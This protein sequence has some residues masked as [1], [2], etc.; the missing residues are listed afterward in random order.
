MYPVM[1]QYHIPLHEARV[2][3][4]LL[5]ELYQLNKKYFNT[6]SMF[7]DLGDNKKSTFVLVPQSHGYHRLRKNELQH[8]WFHTLMT[9]LGG[10]G[11]EA[12]SA[13]DLFVHVSR[14]EQFQDEI[15][16]AVKQSGIRTFPSFDPVAT[17]AVGC[18]SK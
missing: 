5:K 13:R 9:A 12:A 1:K 8:Q 17:F 7:V 3:E 10:I 11:N 14:L 6:R 16:E 15:V 18:Q 2:H 4:A